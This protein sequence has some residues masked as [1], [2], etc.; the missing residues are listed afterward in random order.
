VNQ[1]LAAVVSSGNAGLR[2]LAAE[3]PNLEKARTGLTRIVRYAE[4]ASEVIARIRKLVKKSPP[5][6]ASLD[7]TEA[8][9]EV[10]AMAVA[11]ARRHHVT[12]RTQCSVDVPP[13]FG[14]R[15]QVQ[16]V[17]LNLVMNAIDAM[18]AVTGRPRELLIRCAQNEPGTILVAVRDSGIG[19]DPQGTDRIFDA[20][21]TTK[22]DGLGMGLSI[23]Q[24]IIEAHGGQLWTVANDDHGATFQFT[25]PTDRGAEYD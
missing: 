23:S 15:I 3:P 11:E 16:Q 22:P 24:S 2:W 9:Q 13:A 21:Y 17:I 19:V 20:F 5:A 8:I 12:V 18:K 10:L 7:V 6:E 1:P 25:L 14:D 4:R